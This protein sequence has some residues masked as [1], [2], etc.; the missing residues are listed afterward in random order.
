MTDRSPSSRLGVQY[1]HPP[2]SEAEAL[3]SCREDV[4]HTPAATLGPPAQEG[5]Q[6]DG[7]PE[8]GES[9]RWCG[10]VGEALAGGDLLGTCA[11]LCAQTHGWV[12]RT[13]IRH[14]GSLEMLMD[15]AQAMPAAHRSQHQ[16]RSYQSMPG[17]HVQKSPGRP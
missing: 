15:D 9:S 5:P 11:C 7:G 8:A 12:L 6:P 1:H 16:C 3:G 14:M 17:A 13:R 10:G 4:L 2:G